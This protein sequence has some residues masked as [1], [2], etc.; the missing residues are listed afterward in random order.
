MEMEEWNQKEVEYKIEQTAAL[1]EA[2][3]C[4]RAAELKAFEK[5]LNKLEMKRR[6]RR[7]M[8]GSIMVRGKVRV[9]EERS[10]DLRELVYETL[11]SKANTVRDVAAANSATISNITNISSFVTRFARHSCWRRRRRAFDSLTPPSGGSAS[12]WGGSGFASRGRW[13]GPRRG[14]GER[15]GGELR[16]EASCILT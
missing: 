11:K 15:R 1:E 16:E 10:D 5:H 14:R 8:K 9:S 13:I 6:R 4:L 12:C 3:T 2:K 7:P